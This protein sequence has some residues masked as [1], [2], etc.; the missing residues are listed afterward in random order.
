MAKIRYSTSVGGLV[1]VI[2]K[3]PLDNAVFAVGGLMGIAEL[4]D[5]DAFPRLARP[6]RY[7]SE[8]ANISFEKYTKSRLVSVVV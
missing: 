3:F 2:S 7:S 4:E 1:A 5:V 8:L 6:T